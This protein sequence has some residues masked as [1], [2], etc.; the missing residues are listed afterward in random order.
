M[1]GSYCTSITES[2]ILRLSSSSPLSGFSPGEETYYKQE[3]ALSSIHASAPFVLQA[4]LP[5]L[6]FQVS[7]V[8]WNSDEGLLTM[9][10]SWLEGGVTLQ[11]AGGGHCVGQIHY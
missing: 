11:A 4:H 8:R 7:R 1:L 6:S 5:T 2:L 3:P 9:G 10:V